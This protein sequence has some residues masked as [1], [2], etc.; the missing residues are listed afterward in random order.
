YKTGVVCTIK[1]LLKAD[2][3]TVRVLVEGEYRASL[4]EV[5]STTFE[6]QTAI[7]KELK[8]TKK[9][10]MSADKK[11]A[12]IRLLKSVY[13]TYSKMLPNVPKDLIMQNLEEENEEKLFSNICFNALLSYQQKQQLLET[14]NIYSAIKKLIGYLEKE[15]QVLSLEKDIFNKV[16]QKMDDNQREYF[17]REQIK[18]LQNELNESPEDDAFEYGYQITKI[19]NISNDSREKLYKE[20]ARL[21]SMPS[22]SQEASVIRTYLDTCISLPFDKKTKERL[23]IKKG[24]KMLDQDHYGM[25][26]VKERILENIAVRQLNPD[27]KG[28]IICL[29]GPPGVGKTS[30]AASIARTLNRKY[31]RVSLGGV[32]DESDIRGHR[33]TYIGAMPGRIINALIGAKVNNPLF[34]LDE[35]DK[36]GNDFKGD[37]AS[38]MLEVLDD[39]QNNAFVDHYIEIPFDLSNVMF[40]TTANTTQTIPAPLLDRMEIIELTSYTRDEKFNIAKKYLVKKQLKKH[41]LSAKQLNI[42]DKAIFDIIDNYTRESGVRQLEREIAAICRKSAKLLIT[43]ECKKVTVTD[44]NIEEILY[45]RKYKRSEA[46]NES[47]VGIVNGLAW[48]SV[49]GEMLEIETAAMKGN[50]KI[51]LTGSLGDVMKESAEIAISYVR[52]VAEQYGIE[53]DFYKKYDIHIHAPE[54]AVP[55]DGPSA[56]VTMATALVSALT[57]IPVRAD[58]AMTGEISLTGRVMPIGGLKEKSMAAHREGKKTVIIPFENSPD[59]YQVD[60]VIKKDISFICVKT[61]GEVLEI[62]LDKNKQ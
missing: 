12:L 20:C 10:T 1:Q 49:G 9:T 29:V 17:L 40:I 56:G 19:A 57:N 54:G 30:I 8:T 31:V 3:S 13:E 60:E 41:G 51:K 2:K 34:L 62:A 61:I 59:L 21:E 45:P 11:E 22:N 47:R 23:D 42:S 55:K 27:I 50:G 14:T 32:R 7:V 53:K 38:A 25:D 35:I 15:T 36:M 58:I 43:D 52:T 39:A 48:T 44:K 37:P 4:L 26:K 18:V 28:Q 24:R 33:K 5:D 6:Y 16:H 46:E